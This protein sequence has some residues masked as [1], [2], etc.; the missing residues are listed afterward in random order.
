MITKYYHK[1]NK[2]DD[3]KLH[4]M[5]FFAQVAEKAG[6]TI[7]GVGSVYIM[8]G[9]SG[10]ISF[11]LIMLIFASLQSQ[12]ISLW[13]LNLANFSLRISL[14][15]RMISFSLLCYGLY[16][17]NFKIMLI[18]AAFSGLFVGLFWPTF[19]HL[20]NESIG[21]WH[22]IE[23]ISGV[24]LTIITGILVLYWNSL[25][26][27]I[28]SFASS[29][30]GL[31]LTYN[32]EDK[33]KKVEEQFD[34]DNHGY[35]D[36]KII[37]ILDGFNGEAVRMMR[38][39]VI[40]SGAVTIMNY[41]GILSFALVLGISEALGAIIKQLTNF[42]IF[43]FSIIVFVGCLF[44]G[45]LFDQWIIG[46]I[47]IGIGTAGIFPMVHEYVRDKIKISDHNFRERNRFNGRIIGASFAA[48]IFI[49]SMSYTI[50][51]IAVFVSTYCVWFMIKGE[52]SDVAKPPN[53]PSVSVA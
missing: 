23:K 36:L 38:R 45:I 46:L 33:N 35:V 32:V 10:L 43:E 5:R 22:L 50:V 42:E 16:S 12:L 14:V 19:Y 34:I 27:L 51:F 52:T 7:A 8:N 39:I 31:I 18:G 13:N 17:T 20:K 9:V 53:R 48:F 47:L 41:N 21:K 28:I 25:Y 24:I 49:S 6:Y 26:I 29:T 15:F 44:C 30:I 11:A 4:E 2:S 37:S 1:K 3:T 40:M